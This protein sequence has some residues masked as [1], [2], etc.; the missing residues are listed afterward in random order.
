[1]DD[2]AILLIGGIVRKAGAVVVLSTS[3]RND[4][5]WTT[6]G[7]A[8]DLP[9]VDRTPVLSGCRG[10]EI[11]AWLADHPNVERYAIID[12]DPD[13]LPEQQPYFI[14]TSMFDGFTWANAWRLA[15]LMGINIYDVNHPGQRLPVPSKGLDWSAS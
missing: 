2:V 9:V 15:D 14:H 1:M 5:R 10:D 3:W 13:M 12:D 8:L 11:A 6:Y 7:P 4:V